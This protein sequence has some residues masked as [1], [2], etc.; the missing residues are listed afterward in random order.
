M[1]VPKKFGSLLKTRREE[2]GLTQAD[3]AEVLGTTHQFVWKIETGL[4]PFPAEYLLPLAKKLKYDPDILVAEYVVPVM[5]RIY[6]RAGLKKPT[7][8][9]IPV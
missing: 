9:V 5:E 8:K 7:W 6:Q 4:T 3:V 1:I 2:L